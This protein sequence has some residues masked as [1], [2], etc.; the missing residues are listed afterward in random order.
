MTDETMKDLVTKHDTVIEH[1]VTSNAELVTSVTHLVET[2]KE[3]NVRQ[4]ATNDRLEDISKY[5]SKQAVFNNKLESIDKEIKESF[6]R[7]DKDKIDTDKR[8]HVRIDEL[9]ITQKSEKGCN[10]MR[11]LTKDVETLT[12]DITKLIDHYSECDSAVETLDK[13]VDKY[14]SS[15]MMM[16]VATIVISYTVIFGTYV[17]KS[18]SRFDTEVAKLSILLDREIADLSHLTHK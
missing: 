13:K 17:V 5:L 9:E 2:Q 7:R 18:L 15:K 12:K 1:L 6:I 3:S 14:P 11:L 16:T 4:L 8:I 10:S